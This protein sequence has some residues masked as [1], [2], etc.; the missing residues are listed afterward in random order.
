MTTYIE[1]KIITLSSK[2]ATIK[3]NGTFNS[4][5]KFELGL[6][7][8]DE[9]DIIHRQITLQSAQIP[10]SFY[11]INYTCNLFRIKNVSSGITYN[12]TIPV[13]NY[14]GT[15]LITMLISLIAP[16]FPSMTI[17][18]DKNTG[19]LTFS[20]SNDFI[21]YNNFTYSIGTILGLANNTFLTSSSTKLILPYPLNLL[22]IKVL[23]IR[24]YIL[25]M[26]NISSTTGGQSS[27]LASLPVNAPPFGMIDYA[28]KGSNEMSFSNTSLDELDIEIIDG[29]NGEYINFNNVDWT[30]TL[31][32]HL[33]KL[34]NVP[35]RP[36]INSIPS[37]EPK[38]ASLEKQD[39]PTMQENKDNSEK[40]QNIIPNVDD[41]LG[42]INFLQK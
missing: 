9:P 3:R 26:A 11:V 13:G 34:L 23:E 4:N 27:L 32:I 22:G 40:L 2:S 17:S 16:N 35:I 28:S 19:L 33:T 12:Y 30:M 41:N 7:L 6:F 24:S 10:V 36:N 21:I 20:N 29:E 42:V 5:V 37:V 14:S 25:T 1:S 18:L 15:S 39:I 38:V 8:R 31:I